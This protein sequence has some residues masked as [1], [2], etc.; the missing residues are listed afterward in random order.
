MCD[1]F[2]THAE[3]QQVGKCAV[4]A[5]AV[6]KKS[7]YGPTATSFPLDGLRD[8]SSKKKK[9][10]KEIKANN[11]NVIHAFNTEIFLSID[12]YSFL[13]LDQKRTYLQV[14]TDRLQPLVWVD[15]FGT[16]SNQDNSQSRFFPFFVRLT[17][18]GKQWQ[19]T[20]FGS[21]SSMHLPW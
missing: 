13:S 3:P 12:R 7:L 17:G 20:L 16:V 10:K 5:F 15:I 6:V 4:H 11:L 1:P 21:P 18:S 2:A 9:E 8:K 14:R 19:F